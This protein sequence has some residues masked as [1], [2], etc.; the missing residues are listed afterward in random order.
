M[1]SVFDDHLLALP[2][3][4]SEYEEDEGFALQVGRRQLGS[5]MTLFPQLRRA[6]EAEAQQGRPVAPA[7]FSSFVS[8]VLGS[9]KLDVFA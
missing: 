6:I 2:S 9:M 4:C 1:L 3:S 7:N 8:D 5:S